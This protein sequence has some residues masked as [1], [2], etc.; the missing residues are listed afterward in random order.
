MKFKGRPDIKSNTPVLV[1]AEICDICSACLGVCPPDC[2]VI[3]RKSLHIIGEDC[4][5]CGFCIATCPIEALKWNED[6]EQ[7]KVT[8]H[9]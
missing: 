9:V 2:I 4:I 7:K 1:D 5:N 8:E 3:D 6:V